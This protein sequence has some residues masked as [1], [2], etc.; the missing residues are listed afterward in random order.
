MAFEQWWTSRLL[1]LRTDGEAKEEIGI[2]AFLCWS[3]WKSRNKEHFEK[4][5]RDPSMIL[6]QGV[7]SWLEYKSANEASKGSVP[8]PKLPHKPIWIPPDTGIVKLNVDG[9][10]DERNGLSGVGIVARDEYEGESLYTIAA[11]I[12]KL[13]G[14]RGTWFAE[15]F[16]VPSITF[17][18]A[19]MVGL[20]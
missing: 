10:L 2:V 3:L 11:L 9:A 4:Q 15:H 5:P 18:K 6:E 8:A 14:E 7:A 13:I 19:A 12:K 1:A 20:N 17:A 16:M